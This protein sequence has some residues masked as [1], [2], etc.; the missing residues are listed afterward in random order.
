MNKTFSVIKLIYSQMILIRI[1]AVVFLVCGLQFGSTD[2]LR[3]QTTNA[4]SQTAAKTANS[5]ES[6]IVTGSNVFVRENASTGSANVGRLKFGTVVRSLE[7]GQNA[8]TIGGKSGLWHKVTSVGNKTGWVFGAFLKPFDPAKRETIY[9]QIA[10]EKLKIE[11]RT[12]EENVEL[13]DFLTRAQ[14]EVKTPN[15]AAQIGLWRLLALHAAVYEI[16]LDKLETDP[17]KS[18][19]NANTINLVY[20]EPQ[21]MWMVRSERLWS[22]SKKYQALP[23]GETIAWEAAINS[24]P[25]ECEGFL[26]CYLFLMVQTEGEYLKRFP[27]GAHANQ[28]L[29]NFA[30]MLEPI[31]ADSVKKEVY[32]TPTTVAERA[33]LQKSVAELRRIIS[34][35]ASPGKAAALKHL[36]T[37][38]ERYK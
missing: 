5:A 37:I 23:I 29:K 1:F 25:G 7:R 9:R 27:K 31:A 17:Y 12:F 22:L 6:F 15:T 10:D 8:E 11:K 19:V 30:E 33:D 3:A 21:G 4:K 35:T 28:A 18:F 13:Y 38:S 2:S 32:E 14:G 24:L 34:L 26:T 20:G 36:R 16:P